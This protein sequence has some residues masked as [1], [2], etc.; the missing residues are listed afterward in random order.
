MPLS[1]LSLLLTRSA[2]AIFLAMAVVALPVVDVI[3][4]PI[5][6]FDTDETN[7]TDRETE[8]ELAA[9]AA[10]QQPHATTRPVSYSFA[11]ATPANCLRPIATV[12]RIIVNTSLRVPLRC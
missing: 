8:I 3:A 9:P 6:E 2:V 5:E 7:G 10:A 1:W 4:S 12:S 11:V